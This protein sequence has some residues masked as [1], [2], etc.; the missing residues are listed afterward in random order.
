MSEAKEEK[1]ELKEELNKIL[2]QITYHKLAEAE[3]K[4]SDDMQ[5]INQKIP[6]LIY[7]G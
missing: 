4:L 7:T 5:K 2:D 6:I 3:G 1:K